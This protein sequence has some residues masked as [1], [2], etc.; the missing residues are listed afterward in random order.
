M[1]FLPSGFGELVVLPRF[2]CTVLDPLPC[3]QFYFW[4]LTTQP[5]LPLFSSCKHPLFVPHTPPNQAGW[6]RH[7]PTELSK[8]MQCHMERQLDLLALFL[9]LNILSA[10]DLCFKFAYVTTEQTTAIK[11]TVCSCYSS[12]DQCCN[13][14]ITVCVVTGTSWRG[15]FSKFT[16]CLLEKA[17]M[18]RLTLLAGG[19]C[20]RG[21]TLPHLV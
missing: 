18:P 21:I 16:S 11:A 4:R 10:L 15:K 12:T 8:K 3:P 13:G 9:T 5:A 2:L 1:Y 14:S 17:G 7:T 20:H 19:K 6:D